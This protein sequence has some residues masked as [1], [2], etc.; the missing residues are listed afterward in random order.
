MEK[1]PKGKYVP[2]HEPWALLEIKEA[3]F[4]PRLAKEKERGLFNGPAHQAKQ[5]A[6]DI[7]A[8][9][10]VPDPVEAPVAAPAEPTIAVE[11]PVA[12][13][14]PEPVEALTTRAAVKITPASHEPAA[15]PKGTPTAFSPAASLSAPAE[16]PPPAVAGAA[17][18]F[19]SF[20]CPVEVH[21]RMREM[22]HR[23]RASL[24]G[25]VG[26]AVEAYLSQNGF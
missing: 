23:K 4:F 16:P 15:L 25:I 3:T 18:V 19:V 14:A 12:P 24:Q 13:A 6:L 11:A 21:E 26:A 8:G 22:A 10:I 5:R 7:A 17:T 9:T 2:G 20:R 1:K